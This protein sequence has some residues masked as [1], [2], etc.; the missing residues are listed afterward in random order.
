MGDLVN[1]FIDTPKLGDLLVRTFGDKT[2]LY[3][4]F[5]DG[6]VQDRTTRTPRERYL[7]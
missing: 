4:I 3:L 2:F 1:T 6:E 5:T 7:V